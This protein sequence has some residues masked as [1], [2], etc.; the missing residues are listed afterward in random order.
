MDAKAQEVFIKNNI[1]V[2]IKTGLNEE[3]LIELIP[4]Y[5]ALLVRS[6]TKVTSKIISAGNNLK[7]IGR[8]GS[9]VDNIDLESAKKNNII[10][11]NTPGANSNATAEHTLALILSILRKI[12]LS[13]KSTHEGKWEKKSI[14]GNELSKKVIGLVGLGNVSLRLIELLEGFNVKILIYSNSFEKRKISLSNI[15]NVSNLSLNELLSESDILSFHCKSSMDGIPFINSN[16][17]KK[18]KKTAYIINTSRGNII[19]ENDLNEALNNNLLAGA[20]LDVFSKE[21][22]VKNILFKNPK[23]ILTPHIAASTFEAQIKVAEMIA[24]QVCDYLV[25]NKI[26]NTV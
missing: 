10:V 16:E 12:P 18:M 26:V 23:V 5:N 17:L 13:N 7:V 24:L 2:D 11:M 9:G 21:P 8:A 3:E 15:S 19:N 20:A 4:N 22:A 14:K 6:A 1:D 25:N